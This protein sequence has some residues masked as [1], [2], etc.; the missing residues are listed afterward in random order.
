MPR[1][2]PVGD[3]P[4]NGDAECAVR[5]LKRQ[6]RAVR[7]ALEKRLGRQ[8][9]GDD[10][11]LTWIATFVGDTIARYRKGPD[12]K[13]PWERETGRKWSRQTLEFGERIFIKENRA[14]PNNKSWEPK[15]VE[16]RYVGHH[17]R[18]GSVIGLTSEGV[19]CGSAVKR[20]PE[21][22]RWSID[23]WNELRGLPWE[24]KPKQ[25]EAPG[26]IVD[27]VPAPAVVVPTVVPE[28]KEPQRKNFYVRAADVAAYGKTKGCK[29]CWGASRWHST[30]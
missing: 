29:A 30:E 3:H 9:A 28:A 17:A 25:R 15:M 24:L 19:K 4:A 12:G 7:Y 6:M 10:P 16:I 27:D 23:G 2:A 13:T 11:M 18:T 5:E 22:E 20:L 1:A 21:G 26:Q 8:L 14:R